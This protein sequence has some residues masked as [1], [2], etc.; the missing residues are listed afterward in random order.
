MSSENSH[1]TDVVIIGA[2]PVGLF[3]VFECGMLKMRTHVVDALDMVGGQCA[4]LYPEKPIYDIPAH[5][6]IDG[7]DLIDKLAEQAAPFNPTYHL[8]Q[9]VTTL[10]R[11]DAGWRVGTDKGT[12]IDAK[13]VIIAAGVGAFGPNKP[14]LDGLEAYE[15]T[16]IF[17][18]V[19]RR[20]DFAGKRIVIAGGGDSAVDWANSLSEVAAHVMVV[21][22]RP[23]FRAAPESVSRLDA[24]VKEGKV[25]MVVPYQ[26][27]GLEGTDGKLTGVRVADLDDN[28]KVLDADVLLPFF[29]LA[30]NLGP[31]ADWGL[32]MEKGHILVDQRTL[33]T[34]APGIFAI[35]DIA[36]YPGKLKLI[37]CG[38]SEAAMAAHA[39]HGLV[40]P[41][42]V[43]HFEYSTSKG[44]PGA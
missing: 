44:L 2:G 41:D 14:P 23:K 1:S 43:L 17:Y 34:S 39:A 37:L 21:H 6:A 29:G 15:G 13:A 10:T 7:A 8:G 36:H 33:A 31:I 24:L 12:I 5:P 4:A 19:K 20:Q 28:E 30:M 26:L 25:E 18:L 32:D 38:F 35:G 22:R 11:T 9:Q 42:H 3:A 40:H 27:S 16:G